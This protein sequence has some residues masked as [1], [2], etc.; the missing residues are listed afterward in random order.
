MK[1]LICFLLILAFAGCKTK[2]TQF[3]IDYTAQASI[4]S[5]S[6]I[7]VPFD[8]YTPEQTTNSSYEFEVNDTRKD[9]IEKIT[10]EDLRISI[11]SPQG[12]DF[13]FLKDMSVYISS[14][15]LPEKIIAYKYDIQ[16]SIGDVLDCDET[17]EDLQ[18]Y[19]KADKFTI[20][21]ETVT[22]EIITNEIDVDIYTN[23]FVDAKLVK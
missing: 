5:S 1:Y 2:F 3:F 4:P 8:V 12:E 10:L 21:L 7:D 17:N 13:S 14:D 22:D 9:K 6:P 16:N 23:F 11:T 19:V 20:R 18:A 15:G